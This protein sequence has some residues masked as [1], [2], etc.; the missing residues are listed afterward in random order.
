PSPQSIYLGNDD[1]PVMEHEV[2]AWVRQEEGL[3]AVDAEA[4]PT[5]GRR[6]A[7]TRLRASGWQPVHRDYRSGYSAE[8]VRPGL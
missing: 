6:I 7:N 4:L 2:Q 1:L 8:L 5:T 3:P